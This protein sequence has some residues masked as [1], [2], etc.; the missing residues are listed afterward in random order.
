MGGEGCC[1]GKKCGKGSCEGEGCCGGKACGKKSC[2]D[3]VPNE[4]GSAKGP[5]GVVASVACSDS[6]EGKK[7]LAVSAGLPPMR[8]AG[9]PAE[10]VVINVS[11]ISKHPAA[12]FDLAVVSSSGPS[13]LTPAAITAVAERLAPGGA[14]QLHELRWQPTAGCHPAA[15]ALRD[16]VGLR[17]VALFSG[18]VLPPATKDGASELLPLPKGT[19]GAAA[20]SLYPQLSRWALD[21]SAEAVDALEALGSTLGPKLGLGVLRCSK[22]GFAAGASFSLR[23]RA[24]VATPAGPPAAA[25][26]GGSAWASL[27]AEDGGA[28]LLDE[29]DLLA[30]ED[31]AKKEAVR[32]DCGT[33]DGTGK[34]KACKNCSCGLR[35]MLE[36]EEK[37]G[38]GVPPADKSACGNCALGDAFRCEGCPHRGKPAF[39]AGDEVKLADSNFDAPAVGGTAPKPGVVPVGGGSGGVVKLGLD[40]MV[41]DF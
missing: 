23:N 7:V 32:M 38:D 17:K 9:S 27:P 24:A 13:A 16:D 10:Y 37:G 31:R 19:E 21:G 8:G 20:S 34:R 12:H 36:D 14:A 30:E 3:L 5:N 33:G 41:E 2:G 28:A 29:D 1:G 35:E 6:W 22:P 40:D 26:G 25:A 15:A 39:T 4:T 18:L 11:D